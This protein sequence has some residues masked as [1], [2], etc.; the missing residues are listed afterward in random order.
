MTLLVTRI[1]PDLPSSSTK[2]YGPPGSMLAPWGNLNRPD[3]LVKPD[4]E[5]S[6]SKIH[7]SMLSSK[8]SSFCLTLP[9]TWV[10]T[11][12]RFAIRW[13]SEMLWTYNYSVD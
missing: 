5:S 9:R 1:S 10:M 11:F 6:N 8:V 3:Q 13:S 2:R 12:A 4:R 7:T